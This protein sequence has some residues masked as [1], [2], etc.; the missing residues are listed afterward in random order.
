MYPASWGRGE[1]NKANTG[2]IGA[3]NMARLQLKEY[4]VAD[5]TWSKKKVWCY[6]GMWK[7]RNMNQGNSDVVTT[8]MSRLNQEY[9]YKNLK[10]HCLQANM[11][12][13]PLSHDE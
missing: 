10:K 12:N 13:C 7:A 9:I 3:Y 1:E 4:P 6:I 8:E 5:V 2:R 11:T